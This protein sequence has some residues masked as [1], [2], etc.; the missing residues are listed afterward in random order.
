M[1]GL[2]VGLADGEDFT[3]FGIAGAGD[4]LGFGVGQDLG[5][6]GFGGGVELDA[7]GVTPGFFDGGIGD[8]L[9]E[10]RPLTSTPSSP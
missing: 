9:S 2:R 3:R 10:S 1:V 4:A 6:F 5:A 7:G 8:A